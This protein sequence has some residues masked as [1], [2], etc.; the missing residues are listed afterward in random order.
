[1][2]GAFELLIPTY[3][4]PRNGIALWSLGV[5]AVLCA[6]AAAEACKGRTESVAG[7][8]DRRAVRKRS[9]LGNASLRIVTDICFSAAIPSPAAR[10]RKGVPKHGEVGRDST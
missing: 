10:S 7:G 1:M 3:S 9:A 4:R 2:Q 8:G 5:L 6:V